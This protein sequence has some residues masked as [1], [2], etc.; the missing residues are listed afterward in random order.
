MSNPFE[1]KSGRPDMAVLES[2]SRFWFQKYLEFLSG[3][4]DLLLEF[5]NREEVFDN[6]DGNLLLAALQ[7]L[8]NTGITFFPSQPTCY[9]PGI[10]DVNI[11]LYELEKILGNN[12][13]LLKESVFLGTLHEVT[14]AF[15]YAVG[16]Q[17]YKKG[18]AGML[19][20]KDIKTESLIDFIVGI[21]FSVFESDLKEEK[22][23]FGS[24]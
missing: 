9:R 5:E 22:I 3:L 21:V 19:E 11:N 20:K 18:V 14:H 24:N 15:L 12:K 1:F 23:T 13:H 6:D 16:Y 17:V 2:F 10:G 7:E 8:K 4:P